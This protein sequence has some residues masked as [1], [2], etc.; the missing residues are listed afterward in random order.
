MILALCFFLSG[1]LVGIYMLVRHLQGRQLP[2]LAAVLHGLAGATGF[3]ILLVTVVQAPTLV[4][5]R[6]ALVV[7]IAAVLLGVVN[8]V[9]HIRGRRH[10]TTLILLH[11]L[12]AVV[13]AV[14]LL[15]GIFA[16]TLGNENASASDKTVAKLSVPSPTT[17][18]SAAEMASPK[19][20]VSAPPPQ[21]PE[22]APTASA[23]ASVTKP[24]SPSATAMHPGPAWPEKALTFYHASAVLSPTAR[25]SLAD[26]AKDLQK[27][28]EIT[29]VEVQGYADERGDDAF[30]LELT[31]G[32][33]SGVVDA[34]VSAGVQRSRLRSAGYGA[35]CPAD[36]TCRTTPAPASCHQPAAWQQDRR[37]VLVVL[38]SGGE[39]FHGKVA[40]DRAASLVPAE[41]L[42][43]TQ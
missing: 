12:T 26:I 14:T 29:L 42:A 19:A 11:G 31:R 3:G 41:D 4:A 21:T 40:C 32:R 43:Y 10:R 5:A 7:F 25:A 1:A 39:R 34:L 28:P 20:P 30:N 22:M 35:S 13:G 18:G 33:A 6:Y 23:T 24:P 27:H 9:F 17:T 38:E 36:V 37:V 15:Y 8:L 16:F 2:T